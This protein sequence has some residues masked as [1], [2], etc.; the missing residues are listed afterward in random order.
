MTPDSELLATFARTN[1][2]D[3][4]AELV[5]RHVPL[6]YSAALRQVNGDVHWAQDVT[7]TVFADLA[8]K[9]AV[10]ARRKNLSGWLYTSAR[11]AAAKVARDESRRRAREEKF[12]RAPAPEPAP[13]A[14]WEEIRP[15]LDDAMHRLKAADR[16]AIL[17]RYFENRPYAEV[18]AQL[19]LNEQAARMRVER[20]LEK[21]RAAFARR[22]ITTTAGFAAMLSAHAVQLAPAH[23]AA[24]LTASALASAGTGTLTLL[25]MMTMTKIKLGLA[26]LVVAGGVSVIVMQQQAQIKLRGENAALQQQIAQLQA[27]QPSLSRQQAAAGET[28]KLSDDQFHE[29]LKLRG[30]VAVLRQQHDELGKLRAENEQTHKDLAYFQ[31]AL[32]STSDGYQA[33][34]NAKQIGMAMQLWANDNQ[35]QYPT[36]FDSIQDKLGGALATNFQQKFELMNAGSISDQYPHILVLREIAPRQTP[37]GQWERVYGFVDSNVKSVISPDGN[38]TAWEKEQ[39]QY[40]PPESQ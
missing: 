39:E 32:I 1:S 19:G 37:D 4:F 6:V 35:N 3:A 12:M 2:Q 21:L 24:T 38:F 22:G 11:F 7:Q 23:L 30:E 25:K 27:D 15:V 29:L 26:T 8:R 17:L 34:N 16:E 31:K 10:L 36:S 20:A 18:G 9:A 28:K 14:A 40:N 5:Q 13:E 33:L